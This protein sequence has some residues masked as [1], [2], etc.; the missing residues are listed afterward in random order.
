MGVAEPKTKKPCSMAGLLNGYKKTDSMV[1][2]LKGVSLR[3]S[4]TRCY[5]SS[6][7]PRGK[8]FS[9]E[10]EKLHPTR[11]YVRYRVDHLT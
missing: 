8:G 3:H 6:S 2:F 9:A 7:I 4:N 1:G 11:T 5:K 10:N